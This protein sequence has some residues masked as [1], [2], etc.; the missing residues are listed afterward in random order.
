MKRTVYRRKFNRWELKYSLPLERVPELVQALEGYMVP[1]EHG[2]PESG[3]EIFS[4]YCDSPRLDFFWEKVEGEDIRRKLRFRRY[5][6]QNDAFVEIKQRIGRTV[7]KR[8]VRWPLQRIQKVFL[9]GSP[10]EEDLA[11]PSD[12]IAAELVLLWRTYGL[13][14]TLATWYRRRALVGAMDPGLRVTFDTMSR[15]STEA[16]EIASS[17]TGGHQLLDPR[18]VILETK[19]NDRAPRW[20]SGIIAEHGLR[21]RRISK[22]CRGIDLAYFDGRN[23]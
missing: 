2:D 18:L 4:V 1:D 14:P 10:R 9:E 19:F 7:Q 15:Y 5:K 20:L 22:Y 21:T 17:F 11:D 12:A 23:T 6:G 13:Q 16:L 3:Y 8:R